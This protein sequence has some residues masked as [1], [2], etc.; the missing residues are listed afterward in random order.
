[1]ITGRTKIHGILANPVAHVRAPEVMNAYFAQH[2]ADAVMVPLEVGP[3]DL[4]AALSAIRGL[5][6]L[7]GLIVTVPHKSA[8]LALCDEA[9]PSARQAG[10]ANAIRREP[11][12]R[13]VCEMFDGRGFVEGMLGAGLDP[14]G[15]RALLVGAGGA[16]RAIAFALAAR[17]CGALTI[18]NR[19]MEKAQALAALVKRDYPRCDVRSGSPDPSGHDL[20]VNATSLGLRPEDALPVALDALAPGMTVAEVVMKPE[21]TPLLAGAAERGCTIHKGHHMLDAQVRLLA[22]FIGAVPLNH[23]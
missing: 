14:A 8:V 18:A 20:I 7:G 1:M 23:S 2:G 16:A 10:S 9:G 12:G 11:D 17:G 3:E 22:D 21:T 5:H 6:N 13:L 15:R 19:T 4:A